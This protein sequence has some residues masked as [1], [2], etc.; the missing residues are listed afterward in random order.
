MFRS[1]FPKFRLLSGIP[2]KTDSLAV[3][4]AR[5]VKTVEASQRS[6]NQTSHHT[7]QAQYGL[8]RYTQ[9]HQDS[10]DLARRWSYTAARHVAQPICILAV[11]CNVYIYTYIYLKQINVREVIS[12]FVFF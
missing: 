7:Q 5:L 9:Y 10:L 6:A 2:A 12:Y 3:S 4:G 11:R 1:D 8:Y